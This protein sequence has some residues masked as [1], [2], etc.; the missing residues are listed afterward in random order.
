MLEFTY[1]CQ[2]QNAYLPRPRSL[3][4]HAE[5]PWRRARQPIGAEEY[6]CSGWTPLY[7]A[8]GRGI[9]ILEEATKGKPEDRAILVVMTD[10]LE[11]ASEEFNHERITS[12]IKARQERGWLVTFLGEGLDVVQHGEAM[13]MKASTVALYLGAPGL[14]RAGKVMAASSARYAKAR[15]LKEALDEAA[16][17]SQE[18]NDLIGKK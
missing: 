13:G 15:H 8:I 3:R 10:G 4:L 18:R 17:T 16:F 12:L 7:D 5:R 6:L 9:G 14:R 11:N 1:D 2:K